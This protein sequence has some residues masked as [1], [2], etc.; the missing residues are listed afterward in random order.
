M[1]ATVNFGID[2]GT[3][4]SA[5]AKYTQG[6]VELFRNPANLKQTLPSVVA[7]KGSRVIVG[8]KAKEVLAKSPNN[9]FG[10]FKRKMG[11]SEKYFCEATGDMLSPIALS[12]IVLKELK[13]FIH[14][15][16]SLSSAVITIPAAFDTVQ[17]NATIK[18]GLQ[19]GIDE[20]Y[21]LQEPIAASLAF[22]NKAG[23]NL[24]KG[25]WLV[26]DFGGGT[27]DVALTS[28]VDDEMKVLD[29]EGDNFL[30]G[31]DIDNA[32]I[33]EYVVPELKKLGQFADLES[34]LTRLSGKHNRLYNKLL[35][36]AEEAKITL[37]NR[38]V[39]EIEFEITDD[40]GT[41]LEVFLEMPKEAFYSIV[42][43]YVDRTVTMLEAVIGRNNLEANDLNC[44]LL[45]GGTTYI[46]YVRTELERRMNLPIN[47]QMDP[48]TAVV[49]GA[50]YYAGMKPRSKTQKDAGR[51]NIGQSLLKLAYERVV[52]HD[53]TPLLFQMEQ[54]T[55]DGRYR[56]I[57]DDKG[58]D[59][60]WLPLAVQNTMYLSV[61]ADVLN[62]YELTVQDQAGNVIAEESLTISHG[63]Y[64]IDGQPL[65]ENIC[66]EVDAEEEETT[67]LEPIFRKNEILPMKKTLTKQVSKKIKQGSEDQLVLKILEGP[68]EALPAASK[69]IGQ[70]VITGTMLERDLIKGSDVEITFEISESRELKV[71]VYLSL[72]DQEFENTFNQAEMTVDTRV[73]LSELQAFSDNLNR[74]FT[75]YEHEQQYEK[76][77]QIKE[78]LNEVL[79]LEYQIN[80]IEEDD[81]SDAKYK[82]ARRKRELGQRIHT[83]YN[84]S[85]LTATIEKYYEAKRKALSA[86]TST[87]AKESDRLEL[88]ALAQEE[89][90]VLREANIA[91]IKMKIRQLVNLKTRI[92]NRDSSTV[93]EKDIVLIYKFVKVHDYHNKNEAAKL[94]NDGD[95]YLETENYMAL[96]EVAAALS[97][98]QEKEKQR[99]PGLYRNDGTGLK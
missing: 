92:Q 39:A 99:H 21:L 43:P 88:E 19:A 83:F 61:V 64:S 25:K 67:F 52:Q 78:M 5:I 28:I 58:Y 79:D 60:G 1:S 68:I 45:I 47:T 6:E 18:A 62:T 57:R 81:T 33:F 89:G 36:L 3:T 14:S 15:D 69:T 48:T 98:L 51:D 2:L 37:S 75:Y 56:V 16:E 94:I 84:A 13:N 20:V 74:K 66:I 97:R 76:M 90:R 12:S 93:T 9:V 85:L 80:M 55:P 30:G 8:D 31:S 86:F 59:S 50:A 24:D 65:P 95:K 54:P 82:L 17:S 41:E 87:Y 4:N 71:L 23:A 11:T 32:I 70:I 63:K 40:S 10:G 29:H 73:L 46:P 96:Y 42:S 7:Y 44:I 26:Y 38:S 35:F 77:A 27:F 22:A 49:V 72:T 53:S 34:Q 91:I